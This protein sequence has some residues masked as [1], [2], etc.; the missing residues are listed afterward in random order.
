MCCN[1]LVKLALSYST[2]QNSRIN[3]GCLPLSVHKEKQEPRYVFSSCLFLW[4]H[5]G[6][7]KSFTDNAVPVNAKKEAPQ[8]FLIHCTKSQS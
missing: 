8:S 4:H 1:K 7:Q 5:D 3:S 6:R 2:H